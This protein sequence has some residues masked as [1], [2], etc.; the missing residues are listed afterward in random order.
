MNGLYLFQCV[1]HEVMLRS[2]TLRPRALITGTHSLQTHSP[3][4]ARTWM[5]MV[6]TG[7]TGQTK[8]GSSPGS[9]VS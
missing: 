8:L 7:F 4:R 2:D 5:T 1:R 6:K 9:L 3:C